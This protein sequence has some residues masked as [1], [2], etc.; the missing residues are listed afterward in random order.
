MERERERAGAGVNRPSG[1]GSKFLGHDFSQLQM[2]IFVRQAQHAASSIIY[3]APMRRW[4]GSRSGAR[5]RAEPRAGAETRLVGAGGH[6][7]DSSEF[8]QASIMTSDFS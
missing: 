1:G 4:Q 5:S 7:C 3:G 2:S 8:S 6:V